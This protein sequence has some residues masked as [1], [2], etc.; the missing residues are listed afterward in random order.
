M[1]LFSAS[2]LE[3]SLSPVH[4]FLHSFTLKHTL[5]LYHAV[6]LSLYLSL[7]CTHTLSHTHTT[8]SLS[9]SLSLTHTQVI[10]FQEELA[11]MRKAVA[12]LEKER[13]RLS[14]E[15]GEWHSSFLSIY[16]FHSIF[17]IFSVMFFLSSFAVRFQIILM[18][19][20]EKL[21]FYSIFLF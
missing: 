10:D 20:M 4:T 17:V 7:S 9:L 19:E 13:E 14:N 3:D 2:F 8:L 11:R 18:I 1:I 5:S 6:P 21:T 12:Q 16:I 15:S